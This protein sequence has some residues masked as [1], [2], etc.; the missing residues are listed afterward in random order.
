M[1]AETER[2]GDVVKERYATG[3]KS[4]RDTVL[5]LAEGERY[6]LRRQNGNPFVDP[7][8]DALVGRRIWCRGIIQGTTFVM[9][10]W[11]TLG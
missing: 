9:R 7:K 11:R 3:S 4:E 8:L 6:V 1:T 5:L 10:E 2:S